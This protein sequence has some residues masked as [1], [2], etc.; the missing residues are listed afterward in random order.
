MVG[1]CEQTLIA[2]KPDAVSR[3]ITAQILH[4][5]ERAGL[6]IVGMKMVHA[7]DDLLEIHYAEHVEEDFYGR[8]VAFMQEEPIVVAV[9]E[10]VDAVAVVRKLVGE[11]EPSEAAPGTIRSDFAHMSREHAE[12]NDQAIKNVIHA[13]GNREE[14]ECEIELWF[15]DSEVYDV[16][17]SDVDQIR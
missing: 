17:R 10:G 9:I 3:G 16:Q 5:F 1:T 13:S 6:T 11:L 12:R 14:A 8:L 2:I 4:R 7:S 15:E